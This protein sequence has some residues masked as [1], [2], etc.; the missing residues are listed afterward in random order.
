MA[1]D[2]R[3]RCANRLISDLLA[4]P[5]SLTGEKLEQLNFRELEQAIRDAG[6][7]AC[8]LCATVDEETD[9]GE[10]RAYFANLHRL[11]D[12]LTLAVSRL[13]KARDCAFQEGTQLMAIAAWASSA[14]CFQDKS[15]D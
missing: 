10:C 5:F 11:N 2:D 8:Q 6:P 4:G 9:D 12:E 15:L 14:K 1:A 7:G 13:R 3:V